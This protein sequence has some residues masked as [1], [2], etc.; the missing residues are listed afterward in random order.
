MCQIIQI[1]V[2]ES[3]RLTREQRTKVLQ[4]VRAALDG[5][6]TTDSENDPCVTNAFEKIYREACGI[7]PQVPVS[8]WGHS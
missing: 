7:P 4:K 2:D 6:T 5:V 1:A 8:T 3:R